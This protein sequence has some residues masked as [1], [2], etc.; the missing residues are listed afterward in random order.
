MAVFLESCVTCP[1]WS[2]NYCPRGEA[3]SPA[4]EAITSAL[5]IK[6]DVGPPDQEIEVHGLDAAAA[7]APTTRSHRPSRECS[8]P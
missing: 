3:C 4:E 8:S 7:I 5:Q 6:V 1:I 2:R